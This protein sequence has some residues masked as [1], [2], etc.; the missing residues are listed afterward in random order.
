M[1]F[2]YWS[3]G[4]ANR[5]ELIASDL[6]G[7]FAVALAFKKPKPRRLASGPHCARTGSDWLGTQEHESANGHG[8]NNSP[9][10]SPDHQRQGWGMGRDQRDV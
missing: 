4:F 7:P 5:P 6:L 3:T 9:A 8:L 1:G 10:L 2:A